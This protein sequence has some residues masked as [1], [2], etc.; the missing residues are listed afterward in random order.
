MPQEKSQFPVSGAG[1]GLRRGMIDQLMAVPPARIDFMEVAPENWINVGGKLG[2]KFR[3]FTERYPFLIHGLSLSLGA[4]SPL[5]EAL[6]KDIRKFMD[7]HGIRYYSEHLSY[8]GDTG[9][10][11][12]LMPIP[13][14]A[15]AVN[16]VAAR[17]ARAQ[18]ILGR[19]MAVENVSY[20]APADTEMSEIDFTL[21]VL[22]KADCDLLL[23]I[24]NIVVNSINHRYDARNFM[25]AMPR[26]RVRYFHVAG[27]HVEAEDLRVDTHGDAV[28]DPV[29]QLL[30]DA[31]A[32]FGPVPTLLERDF[33]FP[34]IS[35]LLDEVERVRQ[36]QA[37]AGASP[38]RRRLDAARG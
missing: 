8:C 20:Y 14:T 22:E 7:L 13:F 33:N 23:D 31:Y 12:D 4:P 32:H 3:F 25:L 21:A 27:H 11:Y 30:A 26:E 17:I 38:E 36:L 28:S 6:L 1:L 10:L 35:E 5:N 2:R 37:A 16:H 29:W 18:D 15:D 24:N 34:P 19:R 9:Q